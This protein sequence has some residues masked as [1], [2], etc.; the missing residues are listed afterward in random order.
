MKKLIILL[1]IFIS[2]G[3]AQAQK[4]S[5]MP[6][7]TTIT[8]T[9]YI[10]IIQGGFNKKATPAVIKAYIRTTIDTAKIQ[11]IAPLLSDSTVKYS[12][13][14]SSR[15][16]IISLTPLLSD[17]TVKYST[18]KSS[19]TQ[20]TALT[21]LLSDSTVK[22]VTPKSLK[23]YLAANPAT[24]TLL[25]SDTVATI[26][27]KDFVENYV[28]THSGTGTLGLSDTVSVISTRAYVQNYV[29]AHPTE[30]SLSTLT[31]A[32][33]IAGNELIHISQTGS[34]TVTPAILKTYI[35]AD[36]DT[37]TI[38]SIAPLLA[39]STVKYVTPK[40]MKTYVANFPDTITISSIAPL[41][42]DSTVK[43]V[44]PKSMATY[45]AANAGTGTLT[46]SDTVATISTQNFVENY[47]AAHPTA[48]SAIGFASYDSLATDSAYFSL[49]THKL[50]VRHMG[51]WYG[52]TAS[53]SI[54]IYVAPVGGLEK[55]SDGNF[56][57][58]T[59]WA[60][61]D[62]TDYWTLEGGA[63]KYWDENY[64]PL[65]Q[66]QANMVSVVAANTT[67]DFAFD[68]VIAS[69]NANLGIFAYDG[70]ADYVAR[71]NYANGHHVVTFT[72][73]ADIS[74]G[75]IAIYGHPDSSRTWTID[76]VSLKLH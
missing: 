3:A 76:N 23:T 67:Y 43:Y 18:P 8:G 70:G 71:A 39:D 4:I 29:T 65:R 73:P 75:G 35:K 55:I 74:V 59:K 27:T 52:F 33:T 32:T 47:V 54:K 42:S 14:K 44:T 45:V 38:S 72:T 24:G 40:S 53:D 36:A 26:S 6:S 30:V 12:T 60:Y 2:A 31:T 13:P 17:S 62:L 5:A 51:W 20:I 28:A 68:I 49:R 21:P 46:L 63:M 57:S 61:V 37:I 58:V 7:A 9:E 22:Y 11:A 41:L 25:V 48:G 50:R 16:Q 1:I 69:G 10:P 15:T 34:K 64:D 66:T 19:R 56:S